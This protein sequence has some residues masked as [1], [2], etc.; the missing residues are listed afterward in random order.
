MRSIHF[1]KTLGSGA[2]GTVYLVELNSGHNFRRNIAIKVLKVVDGNNRQFVSRV[3]DEARLLGLLQDDEILQ[4]MGLEKI[5]GKDA[6]LMEFVEG[7]DLSKIITQKLRVPHKSIATLG[8]ICSGVLHRAHTSSDPRTKRPLNV[9]HRDIKPANIMLTKNG[10]IKICDFGVARA[11]FEGQESIT[12]D[13]DV[14]FGTLNY[15]APEYI[16]TG[17]IST[18]AD[19]YALGLSLLEVATQKKFGKPKLRRREH[20]EQVQKM[21]QQSRLP[22]SM[23]DIIQKMLR[24]NQ[25]ER[26]TGKECQYL[27]Y[28]AGDNA[29]GVDLR[30]WA[31]SNLP[32][33]LLAEKE[34]EDTIGLLGQKISLAASSAPSTSTSSERERTSEITLLTPDPTERLAFLSTFSFSPLQGLL[35]GL[36]AGFLLYIFT[37]FIHFLPLSP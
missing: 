13:P 29:S 9:I 31:E 4:V 16:R 36:V 18:S 35:T 34:I 10:S 33:L 28:A 25:A 17:T 26:P 22:D 19:I 14:L 8:A 12:L 21:L 27:F 15:M 11:R 6:I 20:E 32:A 23:I 37:L 24:W 7:V 30:R 2:F 1:L 5:H 3:R